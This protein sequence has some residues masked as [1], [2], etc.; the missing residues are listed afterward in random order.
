MENGR[1]PSV[2]ALK[3]KRAPT[4]LCPRIITLGVCLVHDSNVFV[5]VQ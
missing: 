1:E 5:L 4:R 2:R 3:K